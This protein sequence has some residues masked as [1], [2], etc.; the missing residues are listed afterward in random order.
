MNNSQLRELGI[1]GRKFVEDKFD[2]TI[3]AQKLL[4]I[5]DELSDDKKS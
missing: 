3:Q 4:S 5:I 1:K 2:R